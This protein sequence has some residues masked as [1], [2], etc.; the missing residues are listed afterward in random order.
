MDMSTFCTKEKILIHYTSV[1]SMISNDMFM[2]TASVLL[3]NFEPEKKVVAEPG[4]E[5]RTCCLTCKQSTTVLPNQMT[6]LSQ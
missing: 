4:F 3:H 2:L 6:I 1:C 5:Q